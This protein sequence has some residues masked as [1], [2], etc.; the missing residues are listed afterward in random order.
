M[1]GGVVL[2]GLVTCLALPAA[3]QQL[4]IPG[5]TITEGRLAFDGRATVGDFTGVTTTVT[6]AMTGAAALALVSGWVAAPVASLQTGKARRDRDLNKSM[7]SERYPELR[8]ELT[9]VEPGAGTPDSLPALLHGRLIL[10][11]VS[12]EVALPA[13]LSLDDQG[14]R[15]RS[16]FPVNL[17]DFEV[18][19]LSK[20]LGLLKMDEHIVVHVDLR[21]TYPAR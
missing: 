7:E 20:M 11:G 14:V 16:D 12:R 5:G 1:T 2:A 4:P 3:A 13:T 19:G 6:G 15:V 21:F 8:F 9:Q 17:K 18:G 10:H